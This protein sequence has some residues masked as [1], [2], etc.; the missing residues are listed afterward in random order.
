MNTAD[1]TIESRTCSNRSVKSKSFRHPRITG[2]REASAEHICK[3]GSGEAM[4]KDHMVEQLNY[5]GDAM[6]ARVGV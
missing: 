2:P 5:N 1:G 4:P 3:E 6:Q